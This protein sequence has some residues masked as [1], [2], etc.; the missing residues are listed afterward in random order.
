VL[1]VDDSVV[2]RRLLSEVI[3]SDPDMEVA[4]YA[5]NG[6]IALSLFDRVSPDIV[7]LDIEMPVMDGLAT[8]KS[9]QALHHRLPVIMFSTLTERGAE[10]TIDSLALGASDYVTKPVT[11]GSYDTARELI[12]DALLPKIKAL[13]HHS[14]GAGKTLTVSLIP[15]AHAIKRPQRIEVVAIGC[16]TGGPNALA[17]VLPSLPA[18][19]PVPVLVVQ[20]MPPTFTRFLAQRLTSLCPLPVEEGRAGEN[21]TAGKVWIAPGDYHMLVCRD[22]G[23]QRLQITQG[24]AANS[25]RPSVDVLFRSVA[26]VFS[27]HVLAVVLTGMG[28]DG[29]RG[30]EQLAD[31]GARIVVQDEATSVVWGMPGFV[32]KA[33]LADAVLPLAKVGGA[34]VNAVCGFQPGTPA[35]ETAAMVMR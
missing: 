30:C 11:A 7:T 26:E 14:T 5:A 32:A 4:G 17:Q 18:D 22:R 9:M 35:R 28:Q 8:L 21:V 33:G 20:H 19:F 10:A 2:I 6:K 25:C 3:S 15:P 23:F 1:V 24:P 12:R 31:L 34:I 16:S 29:L 27:S 13:C